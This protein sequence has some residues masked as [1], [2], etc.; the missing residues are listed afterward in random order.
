MA[1]VPDLGP[2]TLCIKNVSPA[3]FSACEPAHNLL[4]APKRV[5][6]FEGV[7]LPCVLCQVAATIREHQHFV[8]GVAV[9]SSSS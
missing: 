3:T 1:L 8:L 5:F 4:E 6:Y 7:I 2:C 9:S